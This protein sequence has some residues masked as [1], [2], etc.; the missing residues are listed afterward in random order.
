MVFLGFQGRN[1][2]GLDDHSG[3]SERFLDSEFVF[4]A[5]FTDEFYFGYERKWSEN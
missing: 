1:G 5:E 2:S 4:R 3:G